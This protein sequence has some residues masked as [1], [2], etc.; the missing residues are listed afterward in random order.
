MDLIPLI[1]APRQT[2]TIVLGGQSL[3]LEVWWQPLSSRWYLSV[4]DLEDAP[5]AVGRQLS[6][7]VRLVRSTAFAGEIVAIPRR[8]E[9]QGDIGRQGLAG[10][11]RPD[12]F[13]RRRDGA[14]DVAIGGLYAATR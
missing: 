3:H 5:I 2:L 4:A 8:A 1:N 11:P 12:L 7:L 10:N 9:D 13:Y 14:G 6:P